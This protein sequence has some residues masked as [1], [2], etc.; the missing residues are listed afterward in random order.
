MAMWMEIGVV[1]AIEI[2]MV[3]AA[4]RGSLL[5]ISSRAKDYGMRTRSQV[6]HLMIGSKLGSMHSMLSFHCVI[7]VQINMFA[8]AW[9][10]WIS[11]RG[12]AAAVSS[13]R[14]LHKAE[15]FVRAFIAAGCQ[16]GVNGSLDGSGT[17]EKK[18]FQVTASLMFISDEVQVLICLC[19]RVF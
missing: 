3:F 12:G 10:A 5:Y 13:D 16:A 2:G 11:A 7:T 15:P 19:S 4:Q 8:R 1:E 17:Q 18:S 6:R 14:Y 9:A